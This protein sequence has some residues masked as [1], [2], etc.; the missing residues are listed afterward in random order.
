MELIDLFLSFLILLLTA[1]LIMAYVSAGKFVFP[2][3][4]N[5]YSEWTRNVTS[6]DRLSPASSKSPSP[7]SPFSLNNFPVL[8]MD[9]KNDNKNYT[10]SNGTPSYS[11]ADLLPT[12]AK[13]PSVSPS[14]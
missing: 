1:R 11:P 10:N 13:N 6:G 4:S 2:F 8:S 14:S 3:S 12:P 7:N 5:N 9:Y